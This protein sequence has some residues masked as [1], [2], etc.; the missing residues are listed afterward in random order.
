MKLLFFNL[1]DIILICSIHFKLSV[2]MT[3]R[4]LLK[5]YIIKTF[6]DRF[7]CFLHRSNG[8]G[9]AML[10]ISVF[11]RSLVR[12]FVRRPPQNVRHNRS[13]HSDGLWLSLITTVQNIHTYACWQDS[14]TMVIHR[15][16][17]I[18]IIIVLRR[19]SST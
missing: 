14:F 1:E 6:L 8:L 12:S 16:I 15:S 4:N 19:N 9:T 10:A 13:K 7:Y 11:V 18:Q 2:M 5:I 17:L 3:H